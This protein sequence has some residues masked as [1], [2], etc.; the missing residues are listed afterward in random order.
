M[1]DGAYAVSK[2]TVLANAKYSGDGWTLKPNS[3]DIV[4]LSGH[5]LPRTE[6]QSNLAQKIQDVIRNSLPEIDK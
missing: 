4:E 3:E 5:I 1:R 2:A 6:Y